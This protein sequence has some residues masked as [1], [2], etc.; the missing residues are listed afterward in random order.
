VTRPL[1][2][3][4]L[5]ALLLVG[6]C[7]SSSDAAYREEAATSVQQAVSQTST[8][9][10][11]MEQWVHGDLSRAAA[12]VVVVASGTSL[13]PVSQKFSEADPPR[14]GDQ[15]RRKVTEQLGQA[16]DLVTQARIALSRADRPAATQSIKDLDAL[17]G[18]LQATGKR[19]R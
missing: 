12:M 11:A 9:Q 3:V 14:S 15:V 18:Q 2:V 13:D 5:P 10:L 16:V 6:G 1:V 19:L 4:L 8:A 17:V 7:G